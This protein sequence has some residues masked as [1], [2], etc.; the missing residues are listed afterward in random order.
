MY[1]LL[2]IFRIT[3]FILTLLF[4]TFSGICNFERFLNLIKYLRKKQSSPTLLVGKS[5][6]YNYMSLNGSAILATSFG[7]LYIVLTSKV[8]DTTLTIELIVIS[9]STLIL[10]YLYYK[11]MKKE[12]LIKLKASDC[13]TIDIFIYSVLLFFYSVFNSAAI[14]VQFLFFYL[15]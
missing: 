1:M 10:F 7:I 14:I 5:L 15:K 2:E 9:L 3:I 11:K 8:K 6:F 12:I 13:V 4:Y